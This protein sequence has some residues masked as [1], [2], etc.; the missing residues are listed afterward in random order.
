M[1]KKI[2]SA[3]LSIAVIAALLA[4]CGSRNADNTDEQTESVAATTDDVS[5]QS[6]D[7]SHNNSSAN[8]LTEKS[9]DYESLGIKKYEEFDYSKGYREIINKIEI[10]ILGE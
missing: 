5:K 9:V 3:L 1:T 2:L 10:K 4:G 8:T 6:I 7:N